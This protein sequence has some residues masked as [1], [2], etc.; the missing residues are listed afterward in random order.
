MRPVSARIRPGI[1]AQ[2]I[3]WSVGW[4]HRRGVHP[5]A[6][7]GLSVAFAA[8]AVVVAGLFV[9]GA[10]LASR[11][12][13]EPA[14]AQRRAVSS[15]ALGAVA[16]LVATGGAAASGALLSFDRRPPPLVL[17]FVLALVVPVALGLSPF[18][19]RLA[20]GVP[21]AALVGAQAFRVPLGILMHQA[22]REGV[23]PERMSFTGTNFDIATGLGAIVVAVLAVRGKAPHALVSSWNLLGAV[24]LANVVVTAVL[25]S[26]MIHAFGTDPRQ[27]NT[28]VAN[29]PFVWLPT[30]FVVAAILG[31]VVV[32]RAL[33]L[34]VGSSHY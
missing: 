12:L 17:A 20:R 22:A 28:F 14:S 30:V 21:L 4:P 2:A 7:A 16:W 9:A 24:L 3:V 15:S 8:L 13:G 11:R 29:V 33:R 5:R 26:P 19:A 25:A 32:A 31:H 10:G 34:R 6:S 27:V 1:Q 18:G 23:M